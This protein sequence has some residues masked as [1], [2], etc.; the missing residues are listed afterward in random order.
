MRIPLIPKCPA[1]V[2][3]QNW[4]AFGPQEP[5][6]KLKPQTAEK[7]ES[8]SGL[9]SPSCIGTGQRAGGETK[10]AG[11]RASGLRVLGSGTRFEEFEGFQASAGPKMAAAQ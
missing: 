1:W 4:D 5:H 7:L 8:M 3:Q 9:Q 6:D 2:T 10:A 11:D